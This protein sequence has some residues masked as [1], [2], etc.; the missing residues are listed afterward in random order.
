MRRWLG[1]FHVTGIFWFR[2]HRWGMTILPEWGVW[3]FVIFFTTFFFLALRRIRKAIA[4]NLVVVLGPCNWWQR[5]LRIYRTMWNFAWCLSERFERLVRTDRPIAATISSQETWQ[6]LLDSGTGLIL[7]T[8][9]LGHW[10]AGSMLVPEKDSRH[11]HVVREEEMDPQAQEFVREL[12]AKHGDIGFT[13]HFAQDDPALGLRL[14]KY[15]RQG[16]IV[17]LQGDRPRTSTRRMPGELFGR[18]IELPAGPAALA[19]AA[20]RSAPCA[21]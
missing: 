16:E 17:A 2:F 14:L 13:M 21:G 9:H 19:R 3:F 12:F 8:A 20:L 18:S 6:E 5:Q 4:S 1:D 10:E 15:L 7:V 11:V